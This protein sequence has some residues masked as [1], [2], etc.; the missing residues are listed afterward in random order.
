MR[1]RARL[2]EKWNRPI[3]NGG[4]AA[5]EQDHLRG[6]YHGTDGAAGARQVTDALSRMVQAVKRTGVLAGC[7]GGG[8]RGGRGGGGDA[9]NAAR[10]LGWFCCDRHCG[11]EGQ[12]AG[13]VVAVVV[14]TVG[15]RRK[16]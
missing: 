5:V 4:P 9:L 7:R 3:Y 2:A 12:S 16:R 11:R 10:T 13:L 8:G 15:P 14:D 1:A 6:R